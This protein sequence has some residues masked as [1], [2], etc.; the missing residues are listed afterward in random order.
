VDEEIELEE[1]MDMAGLRGCVL[2]SPQLFLLRTEKPLK[3][4][5]N[6]LLVAFRLPKG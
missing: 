4:S 5:K 2:A 6:G 1:F 3:N